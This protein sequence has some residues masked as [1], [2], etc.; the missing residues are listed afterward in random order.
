MNRILIFTGALL[1]SAGSLFADR[2]ARP[3]Q[4]EKAPV[5]PL[6]LD[7]HFQF[8]KTAIFLNDPAFYKP[9]TDQMITFERMRSDYKAVTGEDHRERRGHYFTFFWRSTQKANVTVRLEYR[10]EKL[11]PYVQAREVSY[12]GAQGTMRTQF[13]I[14]GDDYIEEGRVSSWRALIIEDGK[15]V[16]LTQSFLWH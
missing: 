4:L 13:Q 16:G 9:T 5:L 8:R 11:G 2:Q 1:L 6:A 14:V 7:N 3:R 15:I 12:K 10:Q